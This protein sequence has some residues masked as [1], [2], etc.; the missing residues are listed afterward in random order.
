MIDQAQFLGGVLAGFCGACLLPLLVS[1]VRL[2]GAAVAAPYARRRR[3]HGARM[4][5][6]LR[7]LRAPLLLPPGGA[8]HA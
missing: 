5:A 4:R 6:I 3:I 1:L 2:F 7:Q 8:G